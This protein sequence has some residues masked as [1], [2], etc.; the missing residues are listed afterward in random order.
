MVH[1]GT[2]MT[3]WLIPPSP[4]YWMIWYGMTDVEEGGGGRENGRRRGA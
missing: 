1:L 4:L 2:K 3:F